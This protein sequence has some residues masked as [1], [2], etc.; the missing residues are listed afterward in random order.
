M[1][2]GTGDRVPG[3]AQRPDH[4][5]RVGGPIAVGARREPVQGEFDD[6]ALD[7]GRVQPQNPVGAAGDGGGDL[8]RQSE[9]HDEAVVVV[10]VFAD[11]VDPA[12]RRPHPFRCRP[13]QLGEAFPDLLC[14]H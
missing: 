3:L 11:Q 5:R 6:L 7:V 13:V 1:D 2:V 4:A 8:V 9:R 14:P 10:G 12:R